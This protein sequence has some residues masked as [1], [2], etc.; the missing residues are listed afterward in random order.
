MTWS[1]YRCPYIYAALRRLDLYVVVFPPIA[2]PT[3]PSWM[4]FA[5]SSGDGERLARQPE[6]LGRG[7]TGR[8]Q[9]IQVDVDLNRRAGRT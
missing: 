1:S 7:V 3:S 4:W 6:R 9:D 8:P 5:L 2:A